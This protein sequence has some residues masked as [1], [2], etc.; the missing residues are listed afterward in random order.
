MHTTK[1]PENENLTISEPIPRLL[2]RAWYP[3]NAMS[4]MP[5]MLTLIFQVS[6]N[7]CLQQ[8]LSYFVVIIGLLRVFRPRPCESLGQ[9]LLFMVDFRV[10]A[11]AAPEGDHEATDGTIGDF[12]Y[13]RSEECRFVPSSKRNISRQSNREW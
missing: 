13:V 1:D 4:G 3:W 6:T 5:H 12:G 2:V 7:G 9:S 10:R 8:S 11:A